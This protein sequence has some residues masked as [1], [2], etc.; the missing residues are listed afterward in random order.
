MFPAFPTPL[1]FKNKFALPL[2]LNF[3]SGAT[4]F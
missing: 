4:S 3:L 1:R 2:V